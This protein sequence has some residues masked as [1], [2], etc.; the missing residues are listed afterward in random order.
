MRITWFI[1]IPGSQDEN[2]S[3]AA[4]TSDGGIE[5]SSLSDT[6]SGQKVAKQMTPKK[7][8]FSV[9]IHNTG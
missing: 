8:E 4:S 6:R 9:L 5:A 1:S 3:V 7:S 2:I